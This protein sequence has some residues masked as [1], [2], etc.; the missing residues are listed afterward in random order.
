MKTELKYPD[1][2]SL[3]AILPPVVD[4]KMDPVTEKLID[5]LYGP[6]E[7]VNKPTAKVLELFAEIR[8][9]HCSANESY[10]PHKLAVAF[11]FDPS[12]YPNVM[13]EAGD[14]HDDRYWDCLHHVQG[15]ESENLDDFDNFL[16]EFPLLTDAFIDH[17]QD[18]RYA[19]TGDGRQ[20]RVLET[21][22]RT[23][24]QDD[25]VY[26]V[27]DLPEAYLDF[28]DEDSPFHPQTLLDNYE[29]EKATF[30]AEFI[31]QYPTL[32]M[33]LALFQWSVSIE[34]GMLSQ[35]S[36]D[37]IRSEFSDHEDEWNELQTMAAVFGDLPDLASV[38]LTGT[39]LTEWVCND[40]LPAI[41]RIYGQVVEK[42]AAVLRS[43]DRVVVQDGNSLYVIR[44]N[45]RVKEPVDVG[46]AIKGAIAG[47]RRL[48]SIVDHYH[49][50]LQLIGTKFL[51]HIQ[52]WASD[53]D[54]RPKELLHRETVAFIAKFPEED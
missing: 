23:Y 48:V 44:D 13:Q 22:R 54:T 52:A 45:G 2:K 15:Q 53:A 43:E 17:F 4:G 7:D 10:Q 31:R 6:W 37:L 46:E 47:D 12:A 27:S 39:L 5:E 30:K 14:R 1:Y 32:V 50:Q 9:H 18:A 21:R 28:N 49:P 41:P 8:R 29:D 33:L 24:S 36:W 42:L 51:D 38:S 11:S 34:S 3:A 26:L 20:R 16:A 35:W 19:R 25:N 40:L